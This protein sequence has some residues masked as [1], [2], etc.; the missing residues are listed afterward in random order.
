MTK[1]QLDKL[2]KGKE[3][4]SSI[5]Y[6]DNMMDIEDSM[7]NSSGAVTIPKRFVTKELLDLIQKNIL[8]IREQYQK[9]FDEL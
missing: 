7:T 4:L 5:S 9:E 2:E 1:E 6:L 8:S 3:L